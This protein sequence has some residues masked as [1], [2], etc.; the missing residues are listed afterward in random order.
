M[1]NN[2]YRLTFNRWYLTNK[3][4]GAIKLV[5]SA[6]HHIDGERWRW[7]R[8]SWKEK[9]L[10]WTWEHETILVTTVEWYLFIGLGLFFGSHG[11]VWQCLLAFC[12][13]HTTVKIVVLI[14][15]PHIFSSSILKQKLTLSSTMSQHLTWLLS[16]LPWVLALE[17]RCCYHCRP[18]TSFH[19]QCFGWSNAFFERS[20]CSSNAFVSFDFLK[21]KICCWC[22]DLI[23]FWAIS[24]NFL[25]FSSTFSIFIFIFQTSI[26]SSSILLFF[27]TKLWFY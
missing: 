21:S 26:S 15:Q 27:H 13:M 23:K 7:L 14:M 22:L 20:Y 6:H 1:V 9:A 17:F 2:E 12:M 16:L 4:K 5:C 24:E 19:Q 25:T 3:H 11:C 18:T 8:N 10:H